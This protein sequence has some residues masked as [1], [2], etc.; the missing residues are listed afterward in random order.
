MSR[1]SWGVAF[2]VALAIPDLAVAQG[3]RNGDSPARSVYQEYDRATD[4][5]FTATIDAAGN[6]LLAVKGGDFALQKIVAPT[7]DATLQLTQGKDVV[8]IAISQAGFQVG[9]GRRTLRWDPRA[10]KGEGFDA[11]R[12][13]LLGSPA[14]TSFKRLSASLEDR[15]E[16]EEDLPLAVAALIDGAIV[17]LLD[18]DVDA[19]KR[20]AKR[21]TRK[22]RAALRAASL[23]RAPDQF[24]DCIGLYQVALMDA[25]N[26][27]AE[28]WVD[29]NESSWWSRSLIFKLCEWE[30]AIRSQQYIW[31]F[32]GCFMFPF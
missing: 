13:L 29:A 31:Q 21:V 1:I 16:T 2:L 9:R 24:R 20:I 14:V 23:K 11:V 30:W 22:H 32:I 4:A 28:C 19:P 17:Q 8:T 18:G 27:Y 6:A 3:R 12:A 15:D 10:D 26:Q 7:G 5:T 25:Y